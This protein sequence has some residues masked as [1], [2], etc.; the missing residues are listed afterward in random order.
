MQI[1][2]NGADLAYNLIRLNYRLCYY[3]SLDQLTLDKLDQ[4]RL[5]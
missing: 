4:T 2:R 3:I 5:Y 1:G